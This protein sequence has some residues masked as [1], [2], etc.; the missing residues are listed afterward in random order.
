MTVSQKVEEKVGEVQV[1]AADVQAQLAAL[2]AQLPDDEVMGAM[3]AVNGAA[4]DL[5][6]EA[7]RERDAKL[8]K[9]GEVID[10]WGIDEIE[11]LLNFYLEK[12]GRAVSKI[13]VYRE[14]I[15]TEIMK[16]INNS[17]TDDKTAEL[18]ND[19]KEHIAGMPDINCE[20]LDVTRTIK[21]MVADGTI[22]TFNPDK[23]PGRNSTYHLAPAS[24][25]DEKADPT[26]IRGG[27]PEK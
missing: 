26:T 19:E 16:R 23:K 1:T 12:H 6:K 21:K 8:A 17:R 5:R 18:S 24:K 11:S 10:A 7:S 9:L 13:G 27:Q 14:E 4:K 3:K 20:V 15:E 2:L 22:C 25:P